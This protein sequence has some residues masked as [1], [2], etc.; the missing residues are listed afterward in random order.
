[1]NVLKYKILFIFFILISTQFLYSIPDS[2]KVEIEHEKLLRIVEEE[3]NKCKEDSSSESESDN[4]FVDIIKN[5]ENFINS[6]SK[7][8]LLIIIFIA[9]A[10]LGF[11]LYYVTR[12]IGDNIRNDKS[13]KDRNI[14]TREY[15]S[16][17]NYRQVYN[18]A[19]LLAKKEQYEEALIEL[20]KSSILYLV[21]NKFLNKIKEYTNNEIKKIITNKQDVYNTFSRIANKAEIVV[22]RNHFI[23]KDEYM[24]IQNI[25][26]KEFLNN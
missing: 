18:K 11:L 21:Q 26:E 1:M 10:V 3:N 14:V 5:I 13:S 24:E 6:L 20:H 16:N 19:L 25:F 23:S 7:Y 2:E 17:F 12:R 9:A 15:I 4:I 22:F 8:L